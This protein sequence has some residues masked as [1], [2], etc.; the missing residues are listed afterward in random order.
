MPCAVLV[1]SILHFNTCPITFHI[2]SADLSDSNKEKLRATISE[3]MQASICFYTFSKELASKQFIIRPGDH[4]SVEAYFRLFLPELLPAHIHTVLY[5]DADMLVMGSLEQLFKTNIENYAMAMVLDQNYSDIRYFNRLNY[6]PKNGY[7]NSGVI[8]FNLNFWRQNKLVAKVTQY[9]QSFPELCQFHDQDAINAVCHQYILALPAQY[10][11]QHLFFHVYAWTDRKRYPYPDYMT[12]HIL[13][14]KWEDIKKAVQ[15][16]VLVHFTDKY[17][18]WLKEC[19]IPFT[20]V[21]RF[22]LSQTVYKNYA[23]KSIYS[24]KT[25]LFRLKIHTVL[26]K[27]H[28][29]KAIPPVQK[30]PQEAYQPEIEILQ[31]VT[32]QT[33]S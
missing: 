7:Y 27:L 12:D 18:P 26:A 14:E 17:K 13:K 6:P 4:V 9:L 25:K 31:Q 29:M 5:L 16:P 19:M 23:I 10:N 15:H 8:L 2:V 3:S 1:K 33:N 24:K 21:W 20:S 30:F 28:V 11:V 22:F 32:T